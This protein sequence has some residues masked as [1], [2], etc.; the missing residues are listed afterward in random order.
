MENPPSRSR[1]REG[2]RTIARTS[3]KPCAKP[4]IEEGFSTL[5]AR[6]DFLS[7]NPR[8]HAP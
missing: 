4:T 8:M 2:I 3:L 6:E 1:R 5:R 7:K